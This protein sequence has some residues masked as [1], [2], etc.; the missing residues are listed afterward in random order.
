MNGNYLHYQALIIIEAKLAYS[1]DV[2]TLIIYASQILTILFTAVFR[3]GEEETL[4]LKLR[5]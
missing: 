1:S 2:K 5:L 4:I 3:P